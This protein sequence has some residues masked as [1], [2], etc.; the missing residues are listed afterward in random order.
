M[1]IL[2]TTHCF[3]RVPLAEVALSSQHLDSHKDAPP[4][5]FLLSMQQIKTCY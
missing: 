5:L 3:F 4:T 2:F 1:K